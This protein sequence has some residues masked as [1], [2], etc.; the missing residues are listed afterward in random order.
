MTIYISIKEKAEGSSA[1][2][3]NRLRLLYFK[4]RVQSGRDV[5]RAFL[6]ACHST[7]AAEDLPE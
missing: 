5:V 2:Q 3:P 7:V 1:D 6:H 4:T